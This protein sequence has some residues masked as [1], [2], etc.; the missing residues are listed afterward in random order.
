MD[1]LSHGQLIALNYHLTAFPEDV[2]FGE[3][4][5]MMQYESKKVIKWCPFD[6]WDI[7]ALTYH[8]S[9]LAKAIDRAI[10]ESHKNDV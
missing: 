3:V 5:S 4:I 2:T 10:V 6:E 7:E 8:I 1:K 9:S